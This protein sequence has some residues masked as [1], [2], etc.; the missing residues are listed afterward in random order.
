MV[1]CSVLQVS[2]EEAMAYLDNR[3][4]VDFSIFLENVWSFVSD[5]I[6][7]EPPPTQEDLSPPPTV[8]PPPDL[9]TPTKEDDFDYGKTYFSFPQLVEYCFSDSWW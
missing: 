8:A 9:D 3:E 4:S 6:T 7:F 5:K 2:Q 1:I